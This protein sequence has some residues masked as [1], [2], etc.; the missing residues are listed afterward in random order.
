[1]A[2]R[3]TTENLPAAYEFLRACKPFCDWK[4]P[5]ADEV[6]FQVSRHRDRFGHMQAWHG[7]DDVMIVIS[8][9]VVGSSDVLFRTLAHEVIHLHQHLR[10]TETTGVQ[11]NAEFKRLAR[12]VCA[13]HVFDLKAFL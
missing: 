10:K 9:A 5:E 11:H 1:M 12:V 6:G 13:E 7:S 2:L 8:E 4:L 3:L